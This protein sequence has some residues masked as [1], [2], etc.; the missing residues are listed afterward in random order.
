MAIVARIARMVGLLLG[1]GLSILPSIDAALPVCGSPSY[2]AGLRRIAD[3]LRRGDGLHLCMAR[4]GLFEPLLLA[5]IAVG[6]ETGTVDK[7]FLVAAEYLDIEV[8][9]GLAAFA[10]LVEPTLI[11]ILGFVVGLI[12]FSIFLPLYALIGS[13]T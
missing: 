1:C 3:G 9:A 7:M 2:A 4:S 10:A 6:D 11:G 8:E 5:L 12:V 13:L